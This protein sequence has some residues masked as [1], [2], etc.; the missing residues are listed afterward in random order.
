MTIAFPASPGDGQTYTDQGVTWTWSQAASAWLGGVAP[1]NADF[2][3]VTGGSVTGPLSISDPDPATPPLWVRAAPGQTGNLLEIRD[4]TGAVVNGFDSAGDLIAGGGAGGGAAGIT[5]AAAD[6]RYIQRAPAV[7]VQQ[8]VTAAQAG[9]TPLTVAGASGQ[10]AA[11]LAASAGGATVASI[12]ADGMVEVGDPA[13]ENYAQLGYNGG[14]VRSSRSGHHQAALN[15]GGIGLSIDRLPGSGTYARMRDEAGAVVLQVN[16][17]GTIT[18]PAAPGS[19]AHLANKT[20]VDGALGSRLTAAQADSRYVNVSGDRMTGQLEMAG[21]V[22]LDTNAQVRVQTSSGVKAVLYHDNSGHRDVLGDSSTDTLIGAKSLRV[23]GP[24]N[25]GGKLTAEGAA[26]FRSQ[27]EVRGGQGVIMQMNPIANRA[28]IV[29]MSAHDISF[30]RQNNEKMRITGTSVDIAD[31]VNFNV[32]KPQGAS[33][34]TQAAIGCFLNNDGIMLKAQGADSQKKSVLQVRKG[35]SGVNYAIHAD[36]TTAGA[37]DANLKA[38][39]QDFGD[40]LTLVAALRPVSFVWKDDLA[41]PRHWGLIAQEA[42]AHIPDLI[43]SKE[44]TLLIDY[45]SLVPVLLRSVQQLLD[46]IAVLEAP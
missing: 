21:H 41:G 40:A 13:S 43:H 10:T 20:Y 30:R 7:G 9:D 3:P 29:T 18:S 45:T 15:M 42:A 39:V 22:L 17:D 5:Q 34:T 26:E 1:T 2:V 11:L 6:A 14:G 44:G 38:D 24:A 16:A 4:E 28:G 19:G 8:A 31:G 37:S 27:V 36:G 46:R 23:T 32:V 25:I 12:G 33:R 35:G